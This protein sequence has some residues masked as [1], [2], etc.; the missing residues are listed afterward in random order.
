MVEKRKTNLTIV[1]F[2]GS[3][4]FQTHLHAWLNA[5][6]ECGG[7]AIVVPGGGP[8]ADQVRLAQKTMAFDD[9]AAHHMA[10][11]A[12]EQFGVAICDLEPRLAPAASL[13]AFRT[14]I[15]AGRTPVWMAA[16]MALAAAELE[17]SWD[18]TSDSLSAWL[19]ARVGAHRVVL[20]KHGAPI[21][22]RPNLGDLVKR[23]IIDPLFARYLRAAEADVVLL[24]PADHERLGEAIHAAAP[25]LTPESVR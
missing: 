8:F 19:A 11:L 18:L 7:R 14:A 5:L 22:H 20:V 9:R 16:K 25:C 10:L 17:Q 12:M 13:R 15:T 2:G 1:K 21:G 4:A 3:H 23:G 6:A 24:G